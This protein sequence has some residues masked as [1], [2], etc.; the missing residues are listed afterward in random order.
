MRHNIK[1]ARRL[2]PATKKVK[3]F[4]NGGVCL[5]PTPV[6]AA[7]REFITQNESGFSAENW[8]IWSDNMSAAYRLFAKLIGGKEGEVVGIPNTS[9]GTAMVAHMIDPKR[10]TNVVFDDLEYNTIYPFTLLAKKG[11]RQRI[12]RNKE[13]SMDIDRFEKIVDDKTAAVVVSSVSCW[14]GYRYDLKPL[15]E[16]AH[17][18]GAYLVVDGA[19]HVGAARLDVKRDGIDFLATCGHKWLLGPPGTGFLYIRED[20]IE[21]FDPPLPGW[22]GID[23]PATFEVWKPVFPRT[24]QRFETGMPEV[25]LLGAI[26]AS[27]ELLNELGHAKVEDEIQKRSGYLIEK[28]QGVKGVTVFTPAEKEHRAGNVTFLLKNH[29]ELYDELLQNSFIV[30]HHPKEVMKNMR[31]ATSGLRVD[32]SFFNTYDELDEIVESTKRWAAR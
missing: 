25:M 31:W 14:N 3:Y 28:L 13:G 29:Q 19:Q 30:F 2:F 4:F 7:L 11:V 8:K 20:L 5:I 1:D 10:G 9:T 17:K 12:I 18:H 26:R 6:E 22:M 23:D 27:M 21:K 16:I 15:A 24:A 32:P